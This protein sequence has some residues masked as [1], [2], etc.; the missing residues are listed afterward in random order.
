MKLKELM[1]FAFLTTVLSGIVTPLSAQGLKD[2]LKGKFLIGTALNTA[3]VNGDDP[4]AIALV[5]KHF[6]SAVAENC[7]KQ[8]A[9]QPKEGL[10]NFKDADRFVEFGQRHGLALIGHCL[11]WH[12]QVAPW[13]FT[14][15]KGE[16]VSSEELKKR[17]KTHIYTVMRRYRGKIKGWDVVNEAFEDDGRARESLYY[18][19]LGPEYIPLAFQYAHEADP[20][21]ELYYNDF[22]M[23]KAGKR[24]AV[25]RLVKDLKKRGLRIDAV[26]MQSHIGMDYPHL[27]EFEKS[28]ESFAAAGVKVMV[29]EWDMSALPFVSD[30][31]NISDTVAYRKRLNP[32]PDGLPEA[33]SRKWNKRAYD[34]FQVLLKHANVVSRFTTWGVTDRTSWKND[35]P[36]KGRVDYPLLFGRDYEHKPVVNEIINELKQPIQQ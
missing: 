15:G 29:T 34:F 21:A 5:D 19:I 16:N 17:M 12:S 3:Q 28:I 9:L 20:D 25:V 11:V 23:S 13:F 33:V 24:E 6:N 26:G 14:D 27:E 30:G 36:V 8:D 4:K 1:S 32:Y 7:M 2:V 22:N 10:F 31:A 18:K 35:F